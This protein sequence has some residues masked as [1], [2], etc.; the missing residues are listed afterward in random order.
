MSLRLTIYFNCSNAA[1]QNFKVIN[2]NSHNNKGPIVNLLLPLP[3]GKGSFL[4]T[5]SRAV[6]ERSYLMHSTELFFCS[7]SEKFLLKRKVVFIYWKEDLT[8]ESSWR[9]D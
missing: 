8:G 2:S 5:I 9:R 4:I 6:I 7:V 3:S 1:Y